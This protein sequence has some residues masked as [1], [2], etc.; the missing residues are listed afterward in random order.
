MNRRTRVRVTAFVA[1]IALI[2]GLFSIRLYKIQS[3]V[4]EEELQIADA[5]EYFTT[6]EAARGQI[7]DRNG[8]V[9][10]TNRASYNIDIINFVFFSGDSPNQRLRE[11]IALCDEGVAANARILAPA[12]ALQIITPQNRVGSVAC[13][14]GHGLFLNINRTLVQGRT[15][16]GHGGKAYGMLCAAYFDPADR[17]GVVMLTNGCAQSLTAQGDARITHAVLTACYAFLDEHHTPVPLYA[18]E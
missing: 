1:A 4:D 9:L 3:S 15:L 8:T 10:V 18:V 5:L 14:T 16:C 13:D 2:M 17:T 12:D 6:I 11:L 7:L